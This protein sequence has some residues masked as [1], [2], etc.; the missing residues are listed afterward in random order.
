MK[1]LFEHGS[2]SGF[3]SIPAPLVEKRTR[4]VI[5]ASSYV[6]CKY[7]NNKISKNKRT[8]NNQSTTEARKQKNQSVA[9]EHDLKHQMNSTTKPSCK[10]ANNILQLTRNSMTSVL[11][12]FGHEGKELLLQQ[13]M[14][15]FYLGKQQPTAKDSSHENPPGHLITWSRTNSH[16]LVP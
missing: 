6:W 5:C 4:S 7:E 13:P 2:G 3:P 12:T 8:R 14:K 16:Q 1:D 11:S 10:L 9:N 15:Q